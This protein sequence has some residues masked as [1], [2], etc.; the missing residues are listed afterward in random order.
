MS[1]ATLAAFG[2]ALGTLLA[3]LWYTIVTSVLDVGQYY[4]EKRC[5]HGTESAR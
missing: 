1:F 2:F 4:V 3:T 5:A